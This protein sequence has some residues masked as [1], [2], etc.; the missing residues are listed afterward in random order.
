MSCL[1]FS[2]TVPNPHPIPHAQNPPTITPPPPRL[3]YAKFGKFA[4]KKC[5][6]HELCSVEDRKRVGPRDGALGSLFTE[7]WLN[8]RCFDWWLYYRVSTNTWTE[9][10]KKKKKE[11]GECFFREFCCNFFSKTTFTEFPRRGGGS[12]TI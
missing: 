10:L 1:W 8:S 3:T 11:E 2:M 7:F 4:K 5:T 6:F 9:K 12:N